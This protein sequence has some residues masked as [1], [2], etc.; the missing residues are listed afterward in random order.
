MQDVF[1]VSL[2]LAQVHLALAYAAAHPDEIEA[3]F[4]AGDRA[5]AQIEQDRAEH[6]KR[7]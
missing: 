1:A 3:D 4:A 2:T 7:Q 6:L 5:L